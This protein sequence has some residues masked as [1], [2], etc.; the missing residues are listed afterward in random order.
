MQAR[1]IIAFFTKL[2]I[3]ILSETFFF[4]FPKRLIFHLKLPIKNII[5]TT[6]DKEET[7]RAEA[8]LRRNKQTP[9]KHPF[10]ML[11]LKHHN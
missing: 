1:V 6:C 2:L 3:H 7:M 10:F 8:M 9:L 5:S 4:W 11:N